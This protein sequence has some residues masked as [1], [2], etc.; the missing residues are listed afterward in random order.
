MQSRCR[1]A[2]L[3]TH[4]QPAAALSAPSL[5]GPYDQQLGPYPVGVTSIQLNDHSRPDAEAAAG[6][7]SLLTEIWYPATDV[8]KGMP[9][10]KFS[11]FLLRG[12]APGSIE[13]AEGEGGLGGYRPGITVAELDDTWH[14]VAVRDAPVREAEDGAWPLI[15]FS[16]GSGGMRNGYTY[17]VE[18]W[19]SHGYVSVITLFSP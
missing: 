16:H 17:I 6:V 13:G 19:A 5:E 9:P 10:N 14:N 12:V 7:R 11:E 15:V 1:L 4:L 3:A 18:M 8:A 2:A